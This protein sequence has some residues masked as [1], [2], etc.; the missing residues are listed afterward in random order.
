MC[1]KTLKMFLEILKIFCETQKVFRKLLKYFQP[2]NE[3]L[4]SLNAKVSIIY[5]NQ[6]I[7]LLCKSIEWFLYFGV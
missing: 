6:S 5:R 3:S 2:R 7:D 1:C 4:D